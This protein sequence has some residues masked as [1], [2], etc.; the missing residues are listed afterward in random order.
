MYNVS[1]GMPC[2]RL[3]RAGNSGSAEK[4]TVYRK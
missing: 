1:C 4:E 2:F 3:L